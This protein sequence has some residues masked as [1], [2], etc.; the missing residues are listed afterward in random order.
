MLSIMLE[1]IIFNPKTQYSTYRSFIICKHRQVSISNNLYL[2]L[3]CVNQWRVHYRNKAN[4][5]QTYFYQGKI[6]F[7]LQYLMVEVQQ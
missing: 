5:Q 7:I 6:M 1:K 4:N 2:N 3:N